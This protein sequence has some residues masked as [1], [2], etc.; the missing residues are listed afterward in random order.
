MSDLHIIVIIFNSCLYQIIRFVVLIYQSSFMLF[1]LQEEGTLKPYPRFNAED[2]V[3][4]LRKAM[5]GLGKHILLIFMWIWCLLKV[6][7]C[8]QLQLHMQWHIQF[9][10][11]KCFEYVSDW[12]DHKVNSLT[13]IVVSQAFDFFCVPSYIFGVHYFWDEIFVYV[14]F[15]F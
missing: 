4:K 1:L 3:R 10:P 2:D 11:S 15:F 13:L 14:T 5:K 8:S 12:Y 7:K 9:L 6:V